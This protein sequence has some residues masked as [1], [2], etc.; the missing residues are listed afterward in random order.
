M[1]GTVNFPTGPVKAIVTPAFPALFAQQQSGPPRI[2]S[3]RPVEDIQ[4][5]RATQQWKYSPY[6]P[7]TTPTTFQ[8]T[9]ESQTLDEWLSQPPKVDGNARGE[10]GR[11][12]Q[13]GQT[14]ISPK[15]SPMVS[16]QGTAK[17]AMDRWSP[18]TQT[19]LRIAEVKLE[20][21]LLL[22]LSLQAREADELGDRYK[23][24]WLVKVATG[25]KDGFRTVRALPSKVLLTG[26]GAYSFT[27]VVKK[28][29]SSFLNVGVCEWFAHEN[30]ADN[31][32]PGTILEIPAAVASDAAQR[33]GENNPK[34][35]LLG[36]RRGVRAFA[37]ESGGW[38]T[39]AFLGSDILA[40][41]I[42]EFQVRPEDGGLSLWVDPT[43]INLRKRRKW[44]WDKPYSA[45]P[46][47]KL[48]NLPNR[49]YVPV[50]T[51]F[52]GDDEVLL[53]F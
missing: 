32:A 23:N 46:W 19:R 30:E 1:S 11:K 38:D 39:E 6:S 2:I 27:V 22:D 10:K 42:I 52:S 7:S 28:T 13:K 35:F 8:G 9:H 18:Q 34:G 43:E 15:W 17:G 53:A 25:D 44:D 5:S 37:A 50:C 4:G 48:F 16:P 12:G 41:S 36:C 49:R 51:L 45:S 3:P 31:T 21:S 26:V 47:E 24:A 14:I 20:K 29:Q 33:N 40:G